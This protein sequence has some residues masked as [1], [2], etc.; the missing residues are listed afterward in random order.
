MAKAGLESLQGDI[1]LVKVP[2]TT[3]TYVANGS[4]FNIQYRSGLVATSYS[5]DTVNIG[6]V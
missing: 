4:P 2:T 3:G 6:G 1:D 5:K